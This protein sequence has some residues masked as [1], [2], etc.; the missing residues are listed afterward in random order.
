MSGSDAL[1]D[2]LSS[3]DEAARASLLRRNPHLV[4]AYQREVER[5]NQVD[6]RVTIEASGAI[7]VS[8]D[9]MKLASELNERETWQAR[10]ARAK[11]QQRAVLGALANVARPTA[12][13]WRVCTTR[14]GLRLL[15]SDNLAGAAKHVRDAVAGSRPAL[16]HRRP[17]QSRRASP[18]RRAGTPTRSHCAA[19]PRA[20][21][22]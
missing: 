3:L 21:G 18:R 19:P 22:V 20:R 14:V 9:G 15:D 2:V 1:K 10:S 5:A 4:E 11:R 8:L 17:R 16:Q 13:W 12:D 6:A 7:V